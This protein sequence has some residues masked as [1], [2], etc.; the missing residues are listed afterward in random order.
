MCLSFKRILL[1]AARIC[2]LSVLIKSAVENIAVNDKSQKQLA[3]NVNQVVAL[4]DHFVPKQIGNQ[5]RDIVA[6]YSSH[7]NIGLNVAVL[8]TATKMLFGLRTCA[9]LLY[10]VI[11]VSFLNTCSPCTWTNFS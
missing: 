2:I 1:F 9:C 5:V 10:G 3:A 11:A 4:G 8:Y 6:K 7:L